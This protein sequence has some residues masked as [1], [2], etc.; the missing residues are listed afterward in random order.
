[1]GFRRHFAEQQFKSAD[2][3]YGSKATHSTLSRHVR[4][5]PQS[6]RNSDMPNGRYVP[7]ADITRCSKKAHP[8]SNSL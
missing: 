1:M 7:K 3:R 4:Y 6:D 5:Y 8:H 2:V